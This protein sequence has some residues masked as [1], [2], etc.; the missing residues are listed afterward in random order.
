MKMAKLLGVLSLLTVLALVVI[1]CGQAAQPTAV[2][3]KSPVSTPTTFPTAVPTTGAT[4]PTPAPAPTTVKS[5]P[6]TAPTT[7]APQPAPSVKAVFGSFNVNPDKIGGIEYPAKKPDFSITPR[8]GGVLKHA[9][10]LVW[11]HFDYTIDSTS[12][13]VTAVAP[14]YSKLV[15]CKGTLEMSTP[16]ALGCEPG[17]QLAES[18]TVS[19]DGKVWTF[20]LRKG[21]KW[22]NVAP[23]SGRELTSSDIKWAYDKFM[24]G[25]PAQ[26]GFSLVDKMETPDKYTVTVTLKSPYAAFLEEGP[27]GVSAYIPP[28]EVADKDGDFKKTVIGTGP[29]VIKQL[30]GKE[31]VVYEKNPNYFIPGAPL[32]DGAELLVISDR[33][34]IRAAY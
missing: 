20:N 8:A 17:P 2:P 22:Q 13:I 33:Q 15:V 10:A 7:Q 21:V 32:L 14:V 9:G 30:Y 11:P 12:A 6:T 5:T 1:S 19:A 31:R 16:N 23:V 34:A 4:A 29:F 27:A 28:K 18:W 25:G 3:T 24:Q 26:G